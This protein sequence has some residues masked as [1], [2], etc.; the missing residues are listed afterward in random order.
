MSAPVGTVFRHRLSGA[1]Q[2]ELARDEKRATHLKPAVPH[3]RDPPCVDLPNVIG[4]PHNSAG[5]V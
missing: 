2:D 5:G 4:S 3:R 1:G